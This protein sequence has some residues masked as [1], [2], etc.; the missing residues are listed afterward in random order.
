MRSAGFPITQSFI[1]QNERNLM[2][3]LYEDVLRDVA[4]DKGATIQQATNAARSLIS[5]SQAQSKQLNG[6][7]KIKLRDFLSNMIYGAAEGT[8]KAQRASFTKAMCYR[9]LPSRQQ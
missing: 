6:K 4:S 8:L 1:A 5:A 3:S 2:Y 9:I 7:E